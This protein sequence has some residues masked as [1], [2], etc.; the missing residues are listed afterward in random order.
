VGQSCTMLKLV[1][2]MGVMGVTGAEGV[3]TEVGVER[4][5]EG[6][7]GGLDVP[8]LACI[9]VLLSFI[10]WGSNSTQSSASSSDAMIMSLALD[11]PGVVLALGV[12]MLSVLLMPA[13]NPTQLL[14]CTGMMPHRAS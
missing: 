3:G 11:G 14:A 5:M 4:E 2:V 9:V 1:G 13:W 6:T 7:T 10:V 12:N 8:G